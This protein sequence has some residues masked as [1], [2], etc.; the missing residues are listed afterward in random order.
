MPSVVTTGFHSTHEH[1]INGIDS[2]KDFQPGRTVSEL[3]RVPSGT[4][5]LFWGEALLTPHFS[6]PP[7]CPQEC[8]S[9]HAVQQRALWSL[10]LYFYLILFNYYL[11]EQVGLRDRQPSNPSHRDLIGQGIA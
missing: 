7:P 2:G 1:T 11:H 3:G 4:L 8:G 6:L 9:Q 10:E 5:L